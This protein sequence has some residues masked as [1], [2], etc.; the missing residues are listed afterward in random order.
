MN[1][2]NRTL[3]EEL[4][5]QYAIG[6]LRGPAR[7]RFERL[8][9][10]DITA[11]I[12]VRRWED[13]LVDLASAITPVRPPASVWRG[14]QQRLRRDTIAGRGAVPGGWNRNQWAMAAGVAM[15]AV[16]VTLW[17]LFSSPATQLIA[18]IADQQQTQLWRIEASSDRQELHIATSAVLR[19]DAS[20]AYELW[21]LPES[22][23][24]P[25]S[26]GLMP[27]S[28]KLALQLNRTQRLALA[29][30]KQVAISLEPQGGSPTGAPTGPVLYVAAIVPG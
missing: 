23:A 7:R 13:R 8:C 3:I 28:G 24:A 27:Q 18:T 5:A 10:Q 4:A 19:P 16:A 17:M 21:A 12:A 14:I 22:G 2:Q 11:L 20:H 30:A 25:V 1:Y 15:L 6:T 29:S 9:Q 26:L